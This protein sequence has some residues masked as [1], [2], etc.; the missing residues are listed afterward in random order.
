MI[1]LPCSMRYDLECF[2][3]S[4]FYAI[5]LLGEDPMLR[6]RDRKDL[7]LFKRLRNE[8]A[9]MRIFTV[10]FF[11]IA[12]ML[13]AKDS[14]YFYLPL[15]FAITFILSQMIR[16]RIF[17]SPWV[18]IISTFLLNIT[19]IANT[20]LQRSP[21]I[22][23]LL[24]SVITQGIENRPIWVVRTAFLNT[25][26]LALLDIYAFVQEDGFGLAY[27]SGIILLMYWFSRIV[28]KNQ[29]SLLNYA[30]SMEEMAHIDPL[31]GLYN[32]R[33]LERYSNI[34][35]SNRNPFTLV[36]CDLDGFKRYNDI[37]G[38]QAG[39]EAL[40]KFAE[41]LRESLRLTD[42]SFRY[43]G[44]EFVILLQG[45]PRS[46]EPLCDRIRGKLKSRINDVGISFGHALFPRDGNSLDKILAI[47]DRAL[48]E[49]KRG[50]Y[51]NHNIKE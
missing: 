1:N 6:L 50:N 41:L 11:S 36:M 47:A 26:F 21:F 5:I 19:V 12:Y 31:T 33:A 49:A 10:I 45:E 51:N 22:F 18:T 34:F 16:N 3:N 13:L 28:V 8:V 32:R 39:D 46:I 42:L 48:Y 25:I 35:I 24:V 4:V 14:R 44:D 17:D 29:E 20:G 37:Y 23:L 43:G 38:H 2:K 30:I 27:I 15:P 7:E 40:R 9:Y